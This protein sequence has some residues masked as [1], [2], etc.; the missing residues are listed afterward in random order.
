M[1][2]YG[3]AIAAFFARNTAWKTLDAPSF[4]SPHNL[5]L[6][7]GDA[8]PFTPPSLPGPLPSPRCARGT[9][10]RATRS[11]DIDCAEGPLDAVHVDSAQQRRTRQLPARLH[12]QSLPARTGRSQPPQ[13]RS[14][15]HPLA[16]ATR[17]INIAFRDDTLS[18]TVHLTAH[19]CDCA[20]DSVI[21]T[22]IRADGT[23]HIS[24]CGRRAYA[25]V[26]SNQPNSDR[27]QA[28]PK[29]CRVLRWSPIACPTSAGWVQRHRR[30]KRRAGGFSSMTDC[31]PGMPEHC[32]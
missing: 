15:R 14:D 32:T 18:A 17:S 2:K 25:T 22:T 24:G 21:A 8:K 26:S 3:S 1:L 11:G 12:P 29:C 19:S 20:Q 10:A 31:C 27:G 13:V 6:Y 5:Y 7:W 4:A 16:Q 9:T 23:Q 30:T 28:A